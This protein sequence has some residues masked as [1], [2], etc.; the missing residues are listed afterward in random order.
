MKVELIAE[1][2]TNHGGSVELAIEMAQ[3]ALDAGA[4]LVKGQ[5]YRLESIN[6]ND[7]QADWLRSA[8]LSDA[9]HDQLRDA[10]GGRYFASVFDA[11]SLKR[12]RKM[13]FKRFKIASTE[14][15]ASWWDRLNADEEWFVSY[16]WGS[17]RTTY[18]PPS[19]RPLFAIP[20]YPTPLEVIHR[21]PMPYGIGWSDHVV[22]LAGCQW[23]IAHGSRVVEVHFSMPVAAR[24]CAWDKTADDLKRLR[25]WLEDCETITSGVSRTFRDRWVR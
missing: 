23:A 17:G 4:T 25:D 2:A 12:L 21:C 1:L 3:A 22:G 15:G 6:P 18:E 14:A 19:M 8:A 24:Q 16:P 13:G 5:A 9:D 7:P 11:E 20:L 10:T